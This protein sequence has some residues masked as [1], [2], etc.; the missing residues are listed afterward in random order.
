M[1]QP[2]RLKQA[3]P[4]LLTSLVLCLAFIGW[5]QGLGWQ[6]NHLSSY[7]LFPLF[8]LSAFSLIWSLYA[9]AFWL[10][11]SNLE[12]KNFSKYFDIASVAIFIAILLH[13]GLLWWQLWRD[14]FG[15][16]PASYLDHYVAPTLK[17]AVILST[18]AWIIFLI[19]ELRY[20]FRSRSWWKY[21]EYAADAAF[22][23]L[24][25][26]SIYIGTNLRHGWLRL[27]WLFYG[28]SLAMFLIDLYGR[29][30]G[31]IS[32]KSKP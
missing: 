21:M 4:W 7:S 30:F 16:P 8:G 20:K 23:G 27:L 10:R 5:G 13:P 17:W 2:A 22:V 3:G 24:F 15:F 11:H 1:F 6:F 31:W 12:A 26:H 32:K 28:V 14:N 9:A 25:I 29:Q 18:I 19:Y